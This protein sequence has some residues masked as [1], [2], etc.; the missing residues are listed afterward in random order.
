MNGS[1]EIE[2]LENAERT[3]MQERLAASLAEQQKLREAGDPERLALDQRLEEMRQ[4]RTAE[5]VI[6]LIATG[7]LDGH[8]IEDMSP[9]QYAAE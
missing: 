2:V 8:P 5:W 3:V 7:E 1:D 9:Y 4:A 6:E